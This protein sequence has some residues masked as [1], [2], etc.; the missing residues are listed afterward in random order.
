MIMGYEIK[1]M[2]P[3]LVSSRE[4]VRGLSYKCERRWIPGS[5]VRGSILTSLYT[6]YKKLNDCDVEEED[7]NPSMLVT[8]AIAYR[9]PSASP[10]LYKDALVAH[11]LSYIVKGV[12]SEKGCYGRDVFT[13]GLGKLLERVKDKKCSDD[14]CVA[15]VLGDLI[16]EEIK[17]MFENF[18]PLAESPPK[19]Y[20]IK[21]AVSLP[22]NLCGNTYVGVE[23]E[24]GTRISVAVDGSRRGNVPGALYAYEYIEPG[25]RFVGMISFISD[26]GRAQESRV[27]SALAEFINSR[28]LLIRIGKGVGRGLGLARLKLFKVGLDEINPAGAAFGNIGVGDYVALL[29]ISPA[30]SA[31][32]S[33]PRPIEQGDEYEVSEGSS[34][35]RIK[36]ISVLGKTTI[37]TGW[38]I[39]RGRPKMPVRAALPGTLAITKITQ[40]SGNPSKALQ[41]LMY[42]GLG[43]MLASQGYGFAIPLVKDP[44]GDGYER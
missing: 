31:L 4:G 24:I 16:K 10:I 9:G 38:S 37:Y 30:A 2:S 17:K 25:A 21:P 13:F 27:F 12:E 39:R 8:P 3:T 22:L 15:G 35:V 32:E 41:S 44:L 40:V 26:S 23:A 19:P 36:V 20:T 43:P 5:I 7:A 33:I 14:D 29:F 11:T 1:I 34:N 18:D 28:E 6:H 42:R